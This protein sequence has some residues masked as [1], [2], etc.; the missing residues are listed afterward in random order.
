MKFYRDYILK[1][2]DNTI[3]IFTYAFCLLAISMHNDKSIFF[4]YI[5]N[6]V[7]NLICTVNAAFTCVD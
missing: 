5:G 2:H 3:L 6:Y 7:F 4:I 1:S